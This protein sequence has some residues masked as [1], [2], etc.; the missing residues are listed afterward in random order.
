MSER[1][2]ICEGD[3]TAEGLTRRD[4]CDPGLCVVCSL[5]KAVMPDCLPGPDTTAFSV[6]ATPDERIH[7]HAIVVDQVKSIPAW[8]HAR[9]RR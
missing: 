8:W 3:F 9:K 5:M 7:R 2:R 4:D 6:V 1:C